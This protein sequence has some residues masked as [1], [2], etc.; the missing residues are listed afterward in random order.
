MHATR[1]PTQC[2]ATAI[3]ASSGALTPVAG[4]PFAAGTTPTYVAVD[5]TG[6]FAYVTNSGSNNISAFKINASSGALTSVAGSPFA[7]GNAP[8]GIAVASP[9]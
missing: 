6:K 8:Y 9:R 5:F 1:A 2:L 7:T 3:N 4:S